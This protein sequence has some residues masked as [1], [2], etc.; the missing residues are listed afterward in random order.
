MQGGSSYVG[1]GAGG[2]TAQVG[3][4]LAHPFR[5]QEEAFNYHLHLETLSCVCERDTAP[6]HSFA[7]RSNL[8]KGAP[9]YDV[10][11]FLQIFIRPSLILFVCMHS[12]AP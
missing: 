7:G 12:F 1:V 8:Q 6:D 11:A 2:V 3:S 10:N 5:Q 4:R 9:K